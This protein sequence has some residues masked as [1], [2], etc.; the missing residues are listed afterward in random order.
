MAYETKVRYL[1]ISLQ[2]LDNDHSSRCMEYCKSNSA[3]GTLFQHT[4]HSLGVYFQL[5]DQRNKPRSMPLHLGIKTMY[6]I[7]I[8][9]TSNYCRK[10]YSVILFLMLCEPYNHFSFCCYSK[11][12]YDDNMS[13]QQLSVYRAAL[14][15]GQFAYTPCVSN[16]SCLQTT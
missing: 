6:F 7:S 9:V 10:Q 16:P 14:Q 3:A 11:C 12:H 8:G 15:L 13:N 2:H 1:G 4:E 5:L